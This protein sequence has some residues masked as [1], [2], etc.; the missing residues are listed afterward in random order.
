MPKRVEALRGQEVTLVAGGWRHTLAADRE[1][2]LYSCGWNKF[3]QCGVGNNDDV[4]EPQ[5][6]QVG[7]PGP[8]HGGGSGGSW[9]G[10]GS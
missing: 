3:G 4:V 8:G 5:Q 2:R 9:W 6:V 1:G 10:R 7:E